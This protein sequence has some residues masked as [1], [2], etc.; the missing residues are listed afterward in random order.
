MG[1]VSSFVIKKNQFFLHVVHAGVA[2][3]WK[4]KKI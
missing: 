2:S 3:G 4:K 1:T